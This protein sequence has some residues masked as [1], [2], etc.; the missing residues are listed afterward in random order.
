VLIPSAIF[1]R[2]TGLLSGF[3]LHNMAAFAH[4]TC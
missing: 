4:P 3:C 2:I 1:A